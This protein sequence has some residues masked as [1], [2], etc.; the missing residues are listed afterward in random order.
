MVAPMVT[1]IPSDRSSQLIFELSHTPAQGEADFLVGEGNG[2]AYSRIMAF[3]H[4][5]DPVTLLI[6][7]AKSGKSHLAR[8]FADRS[9][10]INSGTDDLEALAAGVRKD[11][12]ILNGW[13]YEEFGSDALDL[14][15]GRLAFAIENG[16]LKM[17][18]VVQ[19]EPVHA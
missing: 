17:S 13:R 3:P 9:G 1:P 2:L 12:R 15:E 18:R 6:G 7:P 14:V 16:K 10:A 19:E 8:I 11:L 5:P 4:W